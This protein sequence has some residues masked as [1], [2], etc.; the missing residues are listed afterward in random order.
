MSKKQLSFHEVPSIA[1]PGTDVRARAF[2]E[3]LKVHTQG[4]P[5]PLCNA[6]IAKFGKNPFIILASCL[7]SLRARDRV[8]TPICLKLFECAQTPEQLLAIPVQELER[9]LF[10]VGFYKAKTAVLRAVARELIEKHGGRVPD[11]LVALRSLPGVGLK[12][13]NLVI[14]LAFDI[15][16]ICV[17]VHVHRISNM[18]GWVNTKTPEQTEAALREVLPQGLWI[19]WNQQL[20]MVGQNGCFSK[21]GC[22]R[23]CRVR[24][25]GRVLV[26]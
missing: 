6:L 10:S 7:I 9:T 25:L 2:I 5:Q 23:P 15:P 13:A 24:E 14:G 1:G 22:G 20:V 3:Y 21:R 16:A 4:F 18:L 19:D 17:D 8:T 26:P 11:D 12:T